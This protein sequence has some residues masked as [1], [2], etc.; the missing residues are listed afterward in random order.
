MMC[1]MTVFGMGVLVAGACLGGCSYSLIDRDALERDYSDLF[2]ACDYGQEE[3]YEGYVC[4]E[5][6]VV[7]VSSSDAG[8]S[9]DEAVDVAVS[10]LSDSLGLLTSGTQTVAIDPPLMIDGEELPTT[11][12]LFESDFGL[13]TPLPVG[14]YLSVSQV[15]DGDRNLYSCFYTI[16]PLEGMDTLNAAQAAWCPLALAA[17]VDSTP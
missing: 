11:L 14:G 9:H 8:Q 10:S 4:G 1:R 7:L 12:T 3:T 5:N 13:E 6:H 16:V 15:R 2:Y 17:L